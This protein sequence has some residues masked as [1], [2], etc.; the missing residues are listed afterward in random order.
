MLRRYENEQ[1]FKKA[2]QEEIG[3][4]F[5]VIDDANLTKTELEEQMEDMRAE[6]RN[7]EHEHEQVHQAGP[8]PPGASRG[9][10][11]QVVQDHST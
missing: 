1:P 5:K 3:S 6:L 9:H 2:V 10:L 7:L 8:G 4:L 11:S